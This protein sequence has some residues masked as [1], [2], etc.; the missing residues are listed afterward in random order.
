MPIQHKKDLKQYLVQDFRANGVSFS[1]VRLPKLFFKNRILFFM[2]LMRMSEFHKN[3]KN[4]IRYVLFYL[5]YRKVSRELGF[6]IPLN[7]FGPGLAIPHY[8]TIVVNGNTRVGANCRIQTSTNIGA[9]GGSTKAPQ[10][11]DNV[12][13][14]P[15]VK[16]YGEITLANNIAVAANAAV[17]SSFEEENIMIGGVPAKKIKTIDIKQII[18]HID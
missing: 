10:I 2:W 11:G 4:K 13:I 16:I 15:G 17:G 9:S 6:S 14:G 7:V 3:R 5:K 8:G 1:N 12:Y 18:K